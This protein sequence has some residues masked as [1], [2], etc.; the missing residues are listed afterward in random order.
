[1][2]VTRATDQELR[3]AMNA[4]TSDGERILA[5]KSGEWARRYQ[6]TQDA[7]DLARMLE[8][9]RAGLILWQERAATREAARAEWQRRRA[10]GQTAQD[11]S[12]L[13]IALIRTLRSHLRVSGGFDPS[14]D[15]DLAAILG[16][17]YGADR[18]QELAAY[19]DDLRAAADSLD[20]A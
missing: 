17:P 7:A 13:T 18:A 1:M 5:E 4:P 6:E 15:A 19:L 20:N 10:V 3:A 16:M 2:D 8:C 9:A 12:A 11:P 14:A